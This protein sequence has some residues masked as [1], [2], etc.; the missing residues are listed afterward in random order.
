MSDGHKY[1]PHC[2]GLKP[3]ADFSPAPS[4]PSRVNSLCRPCHTENMRRW[5]STENGRLAANA[6]ARKYKAKMRAQRLAATSSP[7]LPGDKLPG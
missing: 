1:C 2:Y 7:D 4:R 5:R 3:L 6:A